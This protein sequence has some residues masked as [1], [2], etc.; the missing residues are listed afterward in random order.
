MTNNYEIVITGATGFV[1]RHLIPQ[2]IKVFKKNQILCLVRN[3]DTDFELKGR[4]IIKKYGISTKSVDLATAKGLDDLP[5]SPK[6]I[7]HLAAETDTSKRNHDVNDL[8][9]KNLY[10][11]FYRLSPKTHFIYIGT[12]VSVVGRKSCKNPINEDSKACPTNEYTRTKVIG[13][14]YLIDKCK[15]DKFRLTILTPNTIYGKGYRKGSLFDMVINMVKKRSLITRI[16]WPG[17]SALIHVDD[18][19][20]NILF[21]INNKPKSGIPEKYLIYSENLSI[22]DISKLIH[23]ELKFKYNP[24]NLPK[25]FWK[26]LSDLRLH[27]PITENFLPSYLYNYIWRLSI[28]IDNVVYTNSNKTLKTNKIWKPKKLKDKIR[29]LL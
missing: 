10:E 22:S 6:F 24:L 13:E 27:F 3:I 29:E 26:S 7:I 14:K 8:G 20:N 28:I 25:W 2:I 15:K 1:G 21:F 17:E 5:K 11:A 23:K 12:M 9:V 4:K 18:V 19:V 16:N